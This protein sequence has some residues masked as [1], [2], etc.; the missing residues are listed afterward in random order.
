MKPK[1][2]KEEFARGVHWNIKREYSEENN[3]YFHN[4]HIRI[5]CSKYTKLLKHV[6]PLY[7][8]LIL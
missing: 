8:Y 1:Y 7:E 3:N 2:I 4:R 5:N 6:I